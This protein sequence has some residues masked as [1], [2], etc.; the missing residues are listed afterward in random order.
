[1]E[2]ITIEK[3]D[4]IAI[5]TL[6]RP[7]ALNAV[8][9]KMRRE[10]IDALKEIDEDRDAR[11]VILTGAGRAFCSGGDVKEQKPDSTP[12]EIIE[13]LNLINK[14]AMA[15]V[16]L[17]KPVIC[18]VNGAAMG[19]GCNIALSCDIVIASENATFGE[20]FA[21]V[22]L[23]P[24]TGGTYFLP[25]LVGM[26]K[27]K[28]LIF[29]SEV[30][31]AKEA[32]RI[33]LINKVVPAGELMK[34]VKDYAKKLAEGPT[35]IFGIAKLALKKGVESDLASALDFEAYTQSLCFEMED[36]K[37]GVSAFREKRKP[38]FR[39]R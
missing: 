18:A 38:Q 3:E 11:A 14:V 24:D 23:I 22:G 2:T 26:Q 39:G 4:S 37:E 35:A 10:L 29:N 33:G 1:M 17:R 15:L 27:A 8:N 19:A 28:E 6:N 12:V 20:V 16:T 21:R 34:F 5:I 31:D 30:I 7:D 9:M 36:H 25:R 13:R 32:E